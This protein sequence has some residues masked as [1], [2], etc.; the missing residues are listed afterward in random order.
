[1]NTPFALR[2]LDVALGVVVALF[3]VHLSNAALEP[4]KIVR[5][6]ELEDG[7]LVHLHDSEPHCLELRRAVDSQDHHVTTR[8][9]WGVTYRVARIW[10]GDYRP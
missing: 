10:C 6:M 5:S 4:T 1:M 2:V 8:A 7:R 9:P 3:V